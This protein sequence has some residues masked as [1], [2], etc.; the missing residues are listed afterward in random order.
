MLKLLCKLVNLTRS[1]KKTEG[2][3]FSEHSVYI[4]LKRLSINSA[5][6]HS[7]RSD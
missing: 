6:V 5:Y 1:Y 3:V 7:H 2:D 4:V